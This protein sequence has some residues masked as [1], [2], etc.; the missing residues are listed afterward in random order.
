MIEGYPTNARLA[1]L[2]PSEEVSRLVN[3][4]MKEIEITSRLEGEQGDKKGFLLDKIV[5]V[6]TLL[7]AG[8]GL[9]ISFAI[10][11]NLSDISAQVEQVVNIVNEF[12]PQI[13]EAIDSFNQRQI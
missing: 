13:Q 5:P 10:I 1:E 7:F 11:T 3:K 12:R 2:L 6:M 9:L 4:I 8:I